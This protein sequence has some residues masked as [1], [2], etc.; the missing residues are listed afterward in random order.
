MSRSLVVL[1]DDSAGR[2]WM[3]STMHPEVAADQD[4]HLFRSRN[5]RRP[6]LQLT[7]AVSRCGLC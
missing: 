5:S 6:S 1:P 4:V 3:R 2:F 7:N